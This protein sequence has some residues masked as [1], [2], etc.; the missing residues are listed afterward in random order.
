MNSNKS[1]FK[2]VRLFDNLG[3]D[4]VIRTTTPKSKFRGRCVYT[5]KPRSVFFSYK[6]SRY[7]MRELILKNKLAGL[8]KAS[9]FFIGGVA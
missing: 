4:K 6:C 8:R 7:Y 3:L 5:Q 2:V 1:F 9:L